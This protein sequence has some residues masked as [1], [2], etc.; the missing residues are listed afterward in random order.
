MDNIFV[1]FRGTCVVYANSG[2][3]CYVL[4]SPFSKSRLN[5]NN[6]PSHIPRKGVS[7]VPWIFPLIFKLIIVT[8]WETFIQRVCA[9]YV[10]ISS[11]FFYSGWQKVRLLLAANTASRCSFLIVSLFALSRETWKDPTERCDVTPSVDMLHNSWKDE[12]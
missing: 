9:I 2:F 3:N 10:Y 7:A 4:Q 6:V 1:L 8:F 11:K 12:G 5:K